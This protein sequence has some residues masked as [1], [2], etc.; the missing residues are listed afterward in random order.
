MENKI[1][2]ALRFAAERLGRSEIRL[3]H[4]IHK[5]VLDPRE[6]EELKELNELRTVL[7]QACRASDLHEIQDAA[8]TIVNTYTGMRNRGRKQFTIKLVIHEAYDDDS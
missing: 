1:I 5:K 3:K 4:L 8:R 7:T 6:Q 2:T